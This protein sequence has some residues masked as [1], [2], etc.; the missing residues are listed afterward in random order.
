MGEGVF[1]PLYTQRLKLRAFA[2][3]DLAVFAEYRNDPDVA[4]YQD[5][6]LPVT[7]LDAAVFVA[8]QQA[9]TGPVLG[10]WVQIAI[11]CDGEL[12]G[13]VAVGL[14]RTGAHAMIGYTLRRARQRLGIGR[15]AV[16]ALVDALFGNAGVHRIEAKLDPHNYASARLVEHLGFRYEGCA[17]AAAAVR[18]EWLDD[19]CYAL[20][21]SDR[22]EWLARPTHPPAEVRLVKITPGNVRAVAKLATHHSQERFVATMAD[23][24]RDA[25]MPVEPAVPWMRAIAADSELA[26]FVM[27]DEPAPAH[28]EPLLWRLLIDRRHQRRGI[29][30]R[31]IR[32]LA[33]RLRAEGHRVLTTRWLDGPGGPAPFYRRLGFVRTGYTED[34]RVQA[35]LSLN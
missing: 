25:L 2:A 14:D 21:R 26:G 28:P 33:D 35:T 1:L 17:K 19:D 8:S 15:E 20:L 11:D 18:G 24:F 6:D 22:Q 23:S 30:S 7:S 13:D 9:V 10:N 16:A 4:R 34:G 27:L 5:W 32:L 29:G 12:V 3:A 31:V